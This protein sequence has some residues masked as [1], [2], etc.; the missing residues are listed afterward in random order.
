MIVSLDVSLNK[1]LNSQSCCKWFEMPWRS[2]VI[3]VMILD[4]SIF[5]LIFAHIPHYCFH[6][7]STLDNE[8]THWG[9]VMLICVDI[10]IIGSNNSIAPDGPQAIIWTNAGILLIGP[11]GTN[12]SEI[13]IEIHIF[14]LKKL[15]LK[16][17]SGQCRPFCL[18]LNV[19]TWRILVK[20]TTIKAQRD[21]TKYELYP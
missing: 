7:N 14:S 9:W 15:H 11:L 10:A 13:L 17:S 19:L 21:T 18:G 6:D 4:L 20:S 1:L 12:F 8:L 3:D 5:F 16:M 2:C